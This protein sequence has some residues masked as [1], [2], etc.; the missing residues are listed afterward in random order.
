M[1]WFRSD[2]EGSVKTE[3]GTKMLEYL[4]KNMETG[5]PSW[6]Q[7]W[8]GSSPASI[9]WLGLGPWGPVGHSSRN[10]RE[11]PPSGHTTYMEACVANQVAGISMKLGVLILSSAELF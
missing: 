7:A 10:Y 9:W 2:K 4:T 6:S 8:E 11:P 1:F 5:T 3:K